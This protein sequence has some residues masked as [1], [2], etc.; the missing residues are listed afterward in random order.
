M[1]T[2]FYFIHVVT[3]YY[4]IKW[5]L[6]PYHSFMV[7]AWNFFSRG[8]VVL[9]HAKGGRWPSMLLSWEWIGTF[10]PL[11]PTLVCNEWPFR[12][13]GFMPDSPWHILSWTAFSPVLMGV[14][15]PGCWALDWTTSG[16]NPLLNSREAPTLVTL[17][18]LI[19]C[20]TPAG[21][22][23]VEF[24]CV[25]YQLITY[26]TLPVRNEQKSALY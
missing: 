2:Y 1:E 22:T 10:C 11:F 13:P 12:G 9:S 6:T 17:C 7:T 16:S 24:W 20:R 4:K 26:S 3:S 23:S 8:E 5:I 19:Y 21:L 18:V 25:F 14:P 15:N